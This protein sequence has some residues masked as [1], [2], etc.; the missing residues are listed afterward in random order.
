MNPPVF[1]GPGRPG[2]G[3]EPEPE[4]AALIERLYERARG[5]MVLGLE[6]MEAVLAKLG[7][8]E[9]ALA[10]VHV[11]GSNGKGST[12]AFLASILSQ[13]GETVGLYT[14][15]HLSCLSERFQ[16]VGTEGARSLSR[17]A[18]RP[19][20]GRI[21]ALAPDYSGLTF[22]EIVTAAAL[23]AFRE[24]GVGTLVAEAGLGARL[25]A[26]R[27]VNAKVSVLTQLA[28]EHTAILGH[29][30]AAIA[31]EKAF[32]ARPERPLF[33]EA[34]PASVV[35][36][37][38]RHARSIE[39]PLFLAGRDFRA[40]PG[41]SAGRHRFCLLERS[42][43]DVEVGLLGPHQVRNA[44][45]AAQAAIA[46][47]PELDDDALRRGLAQVA[48]P[49]RLELLERPGHPSVLLD[50]AHNPDGARILRSAIEAE[51]LRELGP[52][53]WVSGVLEDKDP[54]GVFEALCDQMASVDLC[55]LDTPRALPGERLRSLLPPSFRGDVAVLPTALA[56]ATSAL[57]RAGQDQGL[58]LVA[59]SLYLIGALR[60][61]LLAE[62]WQSARESLPPA[63]REC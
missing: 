21:E 29:T 19:V 40:E 60:P 63:S 39:A 8:P 13:G 47:S 52:M 38:E 57:R 10:A 25:D 62:G 35:E 22:F 54:A 32:V 12:S 27:S 46:F 6:R 43:E 18:L 23:L 45:L 26:T 1:D 17:A 14:S 56:A 59:G 9:R 7:H 51:R 34:A 16:L 2:P 58:V 20:F 30:L 5:G 48:W 11:A 3:L 61:W 31:A 55:T 44:L 50:G 41:R 53:H 33:M 24:H 4:W 15:P 42:I 28:L 36:V 37:V 49:G